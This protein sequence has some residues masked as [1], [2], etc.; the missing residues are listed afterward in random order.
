MKKMKQRFT[1]VLTMLFT[2]STLMTTSFAVDAKSF[3]SSSSSSWGSS[4]SSY[5]PSTSSFNRKSSSTSSYNSNKSSYQKSAQEKSKSKP[6]P[7]VLTP[8]QKKAKEKKATAVAK[9]K[10]EAMERKVASNKRAKVQKAL[11][12]KKMT[13]VQTANAQKSFRKDPAYSR[14][15]S[16]PMSTYNYNRQRN[17]YYANSNWTPS[18]YVVHS[19]SSFGMWDAMFMWMMLDSI[20]KPAYSDTY[21]HNQNSPAFREWRAEADRLAMENADLRVKLNTLDRE[22]K[23]KTGEP[24]MGK[25]GEGIPVAVY[26]SQVAAT[27]PDLSQ[28]KLG[29]GAATGMYQK[30]C[31]ILKS[32]DDDNSVNFNCINKGGSG[33]ILTALINGEI[34]GGFIQG[35]ALIKYANKLDN[36]DALQATAYNEFVFL[37]TAKDSGIDSIKDFTGNTSNKL[38]TMGSGA[39]Y[40]MHSF[41]SLDSD[42]TNV[43]NDALKSKLPMKK[44]S[45]ALIAQKQKS[46]VMVVCAL[47]CPLLRDLESSSLASKLKM[48]PVN[49]WNF[50]DKK[51]RYGNLVYNFKTISSTHYPNL[52]PAGLITDGKVETMSLEAVFVASNTWLAAKSEDARLMMEFMLERALPEIKSQAGDVL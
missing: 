42:Y 44:D 26:A 21:Y 38:Y 11:T 4:K 46:A 25:V 35:D 52:I 41:A 19:S 14:V 27:T 43:T 22:M 1:Y 47:N 34:D 39:R 12:P 16:T 37:V 32:V 10:K 45:F 30:G 2:L 17:D 49:D 48:I 31:D 13:P 18:P 33:Q 7:K 15:S 20:S 40:T 5:K 23:D 24:I 9:K 28:F 51:D 8:E 3:R 6:K 50:N 29:V 36:L